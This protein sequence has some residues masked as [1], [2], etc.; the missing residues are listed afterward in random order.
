LS[1]SNPP[2]LTGTPDPRAALIMLYALCSFANPGSVGILM[3]GISA[4]SG[5][6]AS[7]LSACM[8]GWPR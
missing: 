1:I 7:G 2:A 6:P 8:M 3:A 4:V 5:T